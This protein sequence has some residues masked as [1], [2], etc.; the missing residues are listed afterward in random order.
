MVREIRDRIAKRC[1]KAGVSLSA[2][3]LSRL[4]TYFGFLAKWNRKINL[5]SLK[6]EPASDEAVDRLIVEPLVAA[7]HM[8]DEGMLLDLGSGGGSPGLILKIARPSIQLVL[9]EAKAR[10]A[11]FLRDV[12]RE[13]GVAAT[14]VVTTRFEEL[15]TRPDLHEGAAYISIRAVRADAALWRIILAFLGPR[16]VVLWFTSNHGRPAV[17]APLTVVTTETLIPSTHSSLVVVGWRSGASQ[18]EHPA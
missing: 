18:P 12:V 2:E 16:G 9:V 1:E 6:L 11:A 13:L 3:K 8:A 10:K 14:E 15:L 4:A 5:T 17:P 7:R